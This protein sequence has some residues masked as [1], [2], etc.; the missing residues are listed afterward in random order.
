MG[1]IPILV[2]ILR[3]GDQEAQ[4]LAAQTLG[5]LALADQNQAAFREAGAITPLI[6]VLKEDADLSEEGRVHERLQGWAAFAL[7]NLAMDRENHDMVV[8]EGGVEALIKVARDG[9]PEAQEQAT[10]A[11]QKFQQ[12]GM[13]TVAPLQLEELPPQA[14]HLVVVLA[15]VSMWWSSWRRC[16]SVPLESEQVLLPS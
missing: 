16:R 5:K 12:A 8:G 6:E 4:F 3:D 10:D 15:V 7:G 14:L 13:T 1:G 9:G 2:E 11:L